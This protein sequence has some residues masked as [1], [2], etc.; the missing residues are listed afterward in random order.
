MKRSLSLCVLLLVAVACIPRTTSNPPTIRLESPGNAVQVGQGDRV[1][2]Q[3]VAQDDKG[4]IKTELWVD[5]RLYQADRSE[6]AKGQ[7]VL[8]V[9][10]IWDADKLGQHTLAVRAYDVEGQTSAPV[11]VAIEVVPPRPTPT[12]SP[13]PAVTPTPAT[14]SGCVPSARFVEDVTV[15]DNT[16]YN[17]GVRFTKTWRLRN[18]GACVWEAGTQWVNIGGDSMG[19]QSPAQAPLAEPERIVDISVEMVAPDAQGT[20]KGFWRLQ[21]P[22]GTF[23]GDQ[24]YVQIVVP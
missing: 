14:D 18:D 4:V 2:V 19:G 21:A 6:E 8:D 1:L 11:S 20:Y 9:I 16:L 23:F 13:T 12:P 10:Q 24:A 17:S 22:D 5:G 3:S 15:P 7:L